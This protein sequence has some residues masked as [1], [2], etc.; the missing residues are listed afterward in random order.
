MLALCQHLPVAEQHRNVWQRLLTR[1]YEKENELQPYTALSI[2]HNSIMSA[3]PYITY[4]FYI[5][6]CDSLCCILSFVLRHFFAVLPNFTTKVRGLQKL[7]VYIE[8]KLVRFM[9]GFQMTVM[10]CEKVF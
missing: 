10:C 5:L 1:K 7:V 2:Q 3:L 9:S 8:N 4:S 6:W